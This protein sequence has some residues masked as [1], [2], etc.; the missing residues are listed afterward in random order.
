MHL[1]APVFQGC[2]NLTLTTLKVFLLEKMLMYLS[3]YIYAGLQ[4]YMRKVDKEK[5]I[6]LWDS[7]KKAS[8]ILIP[9]CP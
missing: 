4:F 7:E 6:S 3:L 9:E 8:K 5:L 2:T 1:H